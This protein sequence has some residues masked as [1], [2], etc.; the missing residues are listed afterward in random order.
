MPA[1]KTSAAAR[2]G[3]PTKRR[4]NREAMEGDARKRI[5][6]EESEEFMRCV[7]RIPFRKPTWWFLP[8]QGK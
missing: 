1:N 4:N 7:S 5:L 8:L 6:A 3:L 2:V